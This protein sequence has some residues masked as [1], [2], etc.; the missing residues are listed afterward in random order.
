MPAQRA[1]QPCRTQS[2]R[3]QRRNHGSSLQAA[4]AFFVKN[5]KRSITSADGAGRGSTAAPFYA[6]KKIF[7]NQKKALDKSG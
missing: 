7:Q 3:A 6:R 1:A 2:S 4:P 5:G